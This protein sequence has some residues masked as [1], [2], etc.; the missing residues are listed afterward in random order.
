MASWGPRAAR[1]PP[2][3][4]L[5]P[6]GPAL[7]AASPGWA[8]CNRAH[9]TAT[10]SLGGG[11][12][13]GYPPARCQRGP[14]PCPA[15]GAASPCPPAGS[16]AQDLGCSAPGVA[17]GQAA[18]PRAG[19]LLLLAEVDLRP[20]RCS[21]R[22]MGRGE[23]NCPATWLAGWRGMQRLSLLLFPETLGGWRRCPGPQGPGV[24]AGALG[25][26][27]GHG[28]APKSPP[29]EPTKGSAGLGTRREPSASAVIVGTGEPPGPFPATGH[30]A[31][32]GNPW[33]SWRGQQ[34]LRGQPSSPRAPLPVS[35]RPFPSGAAG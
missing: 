28:D 13:F 1:G 34:G 8:S 14:R 31:P 9:P 17:R 7:L 18:S 11:D 19:S 29:Q 2:V 32:V 15:L 21:G 27:W 3:P 26:R 25:G 4:V 10:S 20:K 33:A 22:Q 23:L 30:S 35:C 16:S 24:P 12:S 6:R 5:C